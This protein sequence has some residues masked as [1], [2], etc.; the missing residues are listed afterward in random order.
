M[1][2]CFSGMFAGGCLLALAIG[3]Q[4]FLFHNSV[5]NAQVAETSMLNSSGDFNTAIIQ[6]NRGFYGNNHWVV[7]PQLDTGDLN[8][9]RTPGGSVRSRIA[10]GAIITSRFTGPVQLDGGLRPNRAADAIVSYQGKPWLRIT[11]TES[12]LIYQPAGSSRE[13]YLGECYVRANSKYI[14]PINN[15]AELSPPSAQR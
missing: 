14:I 11:G 10:Q 12:N 13:N 1:R 6:G 2:N 4:L 9:R 5:A 7:A 8:C 3:G 15:E